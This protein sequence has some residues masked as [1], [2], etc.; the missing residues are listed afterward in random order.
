MSLEINNNNNNRNLELPSKEC[1]TQMFNFNSSRKKSTIPKVP[2]NLVTSS[3]PKEI[4]SIDRNNLIT[5]LLHAE[6]DLTIAKQ[7]YDEQFT[8]FLTLAKNFYQEKLKNLRL[9]FKNQILKQQIYFEQELIDLSKEYIKDFEALAPKTTSR[10][11]AKHDKEQHA[12]KLFK[13]EM[14]KLVEYMRESLVN[15]SDTLMEAF[16]TCEV[17]KRINLSLNINSSLCQDSDE[18]DDEKI[19]IKN[20]QSEMENLLLV[21]DEIELQH[22]ERK[23][24]LSKKS[25][26]FTK[27]KSKLK[28]IEQ[29]YETL[30]KNITNL[31]YESFVYKQLWLERQRLF[32]P[33]N[34]LIESKTSSHS[35]SNSSL[36][37]NSTSSSS[38]IN[39]NSDFDE[40]L[41]NLGEDYNRKLEIINNLIDLHKAKS[42]S[43]DLWQVKNS[44]SI[45]SIDKIEPQ[46]LIVCEREAE[47]LKRENSS[48]DLA[49][50]ST[51]G[52]KV[53]VENCS[54]KLDRDISNWFITR[55]IDD[56]SVFKYRLPNGSIIK[57]GKDLKIPTPFQ[58][59]EL[60]FLIAIKQKINDNENYAKLKIRT[61]LV[62]P[63]GIVKA[64]HTQ[65]IP[66]FYHEIFKYASLIQFL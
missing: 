11:A 43:R 37:E 10:N 45:L 62:S 16:E 61:K 59:N 18:L 38:S 60:D 9:T 65:E 3:S 17:L 46:A 33:N 7:D 42:S 58:N 35:S 23:K 54:L 66:Q 25:K 29:K 21:M 22:L 13:N 40:E 12:I 1:L 36:N 63:D 19:A 32:T 48:L 47:N 24:I 57:S 49:E 14:K 8:K 51:D 6:N 53:V 28:Y 27:L 30:R 55:Q 2:S 15:T 41:D 52:G 56:M 44:K 34:N 20:F 39:C 64:V 4:N 50:C 31:K 26:F 5:C